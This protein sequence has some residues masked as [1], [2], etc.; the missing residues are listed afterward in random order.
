MTEADQEKQKLFMALFDPVNERLS[1][2][3][4]SVVWNSEDAKDI[5]GE[6]VLVSYQSLDK[7]KDNEAFLYFL[8]GIASRIIKQRERK[9]KLWQI[10][11]TNQSAK[12]QQNVPAN[13]ESK[14][15]MELF[16]KSLLKLKLK[17]REAI[18]MFE[19]S[20][21]SL[22]EIQEVQQDSLSAV[23]MRLS[24]AREKLAKLMGIND[25]NYATDSFTTKNK[26]T[27]NNRTVKATVKNEIIDFTT[28]KP[29][30]NAEKTNK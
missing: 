16:Y 23:K 12:Q 22:K 29:Y 25:D 28:I 21:F 5:M 18:V 15:D 26:N 14:L 27:G 24:R 3:I 10:F 19:I 6:T 7:L 4:Q 17:E 8:F 13:P 30:G 11:S 2:Y 9:R 1:R 20:G